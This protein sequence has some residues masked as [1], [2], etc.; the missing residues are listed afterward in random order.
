[1]R[2]IL[3]ALLL[4]ISTTN[5]FNWQWGSNN[6]VKWASNCDFNGHD[7]GSQGSRAEDCGDLCVSNQQCTH[8][9]HWNGVC[10]MKKANYPTA[11]DSNG[12]VCG[13]VDNRKGGGGGGESGV[14]TRYWDCCK[15]SCAWSANVA[16]GRN[17][18]SCN[19]DGASIA[20]KNAQSGCNGGPS[21]SCSNNQPITVNDNLSY[22]FAAFSRPNSCCKCYQLTFTNTAV[23]GKTMIVQA[24]NTGDDLGQGHFDLMI[25]GGGVGIFNGC[26]AQ[27]GAPSDGWGQRYGGVSSRD[28]C[29]QLPSQL[30][31]GCYWRFDWFKNAQ[32]PNVNFKLVSCPSQLTSISGCAA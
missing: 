18:N 1:M 4:V 29:N 16:S 21:Y 25:P 27:W 22:G 31:Q 19:K 3:V 5:A 13:W 8:F 12:A 24:T 20:D 7:I 11:R 15:V 30:R 9:T 32:N 23:A 2:L 28:Q 26:S 6:Q 14:T 17:V 10:Y